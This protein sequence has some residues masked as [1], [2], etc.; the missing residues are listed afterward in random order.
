MERVLTTSADGSHSIFVPALGE[1]YHSVHGAIQESQHVFIN[2]GWQMLSA[3]LKTIHVLE[4]GMGTGLNVLL[5][6]IENE[7]SNLPPK[8]IYYTAIETL[9]LS[10]DLVTKLNYSVLL[11]NKADQVAAVFEA[12]H[13]TKWDSK[14]EKIAPNFFL[15]KIRSPLQSTNLLPCHYH[16]IYFDAFAPNIQPELWQLSIFEQLYAALQVNGILTT[17]CAKGNVRRNMQTAGFVVER[18]AGPPGKRQMIKAIKPT[19]I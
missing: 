8:R 3:D 2:A 16:I 18:I 11:N 9:P 14:N 17:Y 7:T 19:T 6:Y 5:T 15:Q 1:H 4:V 10:P 13:N 12:I